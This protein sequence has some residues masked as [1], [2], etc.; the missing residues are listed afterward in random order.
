MKQL[1]NEISQI[2][3]DLIQNLKIKIISISILDQHFFENRQLCIKL[4]LIDIEL[5]SNHI[6]S[7]SCINF[8]LSPILAWQLKSFI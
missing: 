6:L 1:Q 7:V 5:I 4:Y 2:S 8:S 3:T